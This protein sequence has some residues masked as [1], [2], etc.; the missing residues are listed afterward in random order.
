MADINP[1]KNHYDQEEIM[2]RVRENLKHH[3]PY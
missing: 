3:K 2:E 1:K